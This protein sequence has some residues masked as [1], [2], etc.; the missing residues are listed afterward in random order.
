M[1]AVAID[2]EFQWPMWTAI[3]GGIGL[4]YFMSKYAGG[5]K[6][7]QEMFK[8]L[9]ETRSA[10]D[11][12]IATAG[13]AMVLVASLSAIEKLLREKLKSTE[14]ALKKEREASAEMQQMHHKN[15][16]IMQ[17]KRAAIDE[18]N[19][20]KAEI[21]QLE[22]ANEDWKRRHA[23]LEARYAELEAKLKEKKGVVRNK[24]ATR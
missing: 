11:A 21:L 8:E 12:A 14:E 22:K 16:G 19:L 7:M 2:K 3:A 4:Y 15:S 9:E 5:V 10:R 18:I 20:R 17:N 24:A 6:K 13:Q 1:A 23:N